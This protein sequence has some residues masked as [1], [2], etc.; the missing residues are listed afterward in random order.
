M[1]GWELVDSELNTTVE[2][3]NWGTFKGQVA[4]IFF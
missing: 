4:A 2:R 1:V 3:R